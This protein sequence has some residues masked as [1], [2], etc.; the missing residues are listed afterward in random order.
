MVNSPNL[1]FKEGKQWNLYN[2][3][4]WYRSSEVTR[5]WQQNTNFS[6]KV[7]QINDEIKKQEKENNSGEAQNEVPTVTD[8][9]VAIEPTELLQTDGE[10]DYKT[11]AGTSLLYISNS[12]NEIFKDIN[13]QKTYI[14][15]AGRWYQSGNMNGPWEYVPSDKLPADFAKIPE[16]S[17][18]DAVLANVGGTEQAEEAK[19]DGEIPQTAKVDRK[20]ATVDVQYDGDPVFNFIEG[21]SL[22]L[23]ENSNLTVMIDASGNYFALDNGVW[24]VSDDP[25]GPWMVAN[26]RPRDIDDIP[27]SSPAYN[28]KY[29]YIY[30]YT[31]DYVYTGYTS[32]YLGSYSYGPTIVYGTGYHYKPWFRRA[33]YPRPFTWG[34]GFMYDPWYGWNMNWGYHFGF[35]H[36]GFNYGRN[37]GYGGG[38]FGPSRYCPSYRQPYWGGGYYGRN[39]GRRDYYNDNRYYG[40]TPA[41][42]YENPSVVRE[43]SRGIAWRNNYNIYNNQRGVITRNVVRTR[44]LNRVAASN[45]QNLSV[46]RSIRSNNNINRSTDNNYRVTSPASTGNNKRLSRINNGRQPEVHNPNAGV[47]R[48]DNTLTERNTNENR[49]NI[50]NNT[51]PSNRDRQLNRQQQSGEHRVIRQNN[52][53]RDEPAVTNPATSP[54]PSVTNRLNAREER[55]T[56]TR[57]A[58]QRPEINNRPSAPVQRPE[59]NNRQSAPVQRPEFNNRQSSPPPQR[60]TITNSQPAQSGGSPRGNNAEQGRRPDRR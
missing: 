15:I 9:I 51:R 41:S 47:S 54:R 31:P 33:Y 11:L 38:W 56:I 39:S 24:F 40:R 30:D 37:Y 32:G 21:T 44:S 18:K 4:T 23:A 7:K 29:V 12:P 22:Q 34:F 43:E 6:D 42:S 55:P 46:G 36:A 10:P 25:Y 59:V 16:G 27:A 17:D 5:G 48:D 13:S 35:F 26:D 58:E 57:P 20:T 52:T 1:I 45:R 53:N 28:T 14:L 50:Q 49:G 2:G 3:G 8:I 19:I 60:P